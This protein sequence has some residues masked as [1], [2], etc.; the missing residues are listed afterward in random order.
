M[1]KAALFFILIIGVRPLAF[2]LHET[3]F[4]LGYEHGFLMET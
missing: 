4:S 1:R 2:T 3:W